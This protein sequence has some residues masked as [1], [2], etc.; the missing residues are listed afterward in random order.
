MKP[1]IAFESRTFYSWEYAVQLAVVLV[2]QQ[3]MEKRRR[4]QNA[5]ITGRWL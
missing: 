4:F 5:P 3:M 1:Y 2:H